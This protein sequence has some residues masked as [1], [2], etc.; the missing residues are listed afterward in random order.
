MMAHQ[1]SNIPWNVLASNLKWSKTQNTENGN[2]NLRFKPGQ[3]KQIH[4]FVEA[5]TRNI[6]E[7]SSTSRKRYPDRYDAPNPQDIILDDA[8]V[9]RITPTVHRL[10]SHKSWKYPG[11][12]TSKPPARGEICRHKDGDTECQCP[13]PYEERR[14]SS[15][16]R[17]YTYNRCYE[18]VKDNEKAFF[19]LELVKTLLLYG[20]MDIIFRVCAH[21][22][23]DLWTWW[24]MFECYCNPRDL[25][26]NVICTT[27]LLP[28]IGLN[29]IF[30]FPETWDE[31]SG[32]TDE[33]DYRRMAIYQYM[34]KKCTQSGMGSEVATHP[35]RQFFGIEDEQFRWYTS[36][37]YGSLS[38]EVFLN[39]HVL[40]ETKPGRSDVAQVQQILYSRGL[41][42]E[43]VLDIMAM[44]EYTP[45]GRLPVPHHPFHRENWD[46]LAKYLKFCWQVLIR[47]DM[48][49]SALGMVIPWPQLISDA[50]VELLQWSQKRWW[51][52][53]D[54]ENTF[55]L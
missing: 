33:K 12:K 22:G 13:I 7:H 30:C 36:L 54:C 21:P 41:P 42:M 11:F 29:V 8:T 46:E 10:R 26:W 4:Y 9:R 14:A 45:R 27:A 1:A 5:L 39:C 43:L 32:M 17:K 28:Y 18:F 34:L 24:D 55:F 53:D 23:V 44:A 16:Y 19:N 37:P 51:T 40:T 48:M 2:L 38:F 52:R 31:A 47:C 50:L 49:A 35:H 25:G 20:E 15:F 3:G 6:R